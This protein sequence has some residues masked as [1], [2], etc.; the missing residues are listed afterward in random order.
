MSG[1]YYNVIKKGSV[2]KI[3]ERDTDQR[4]GEPCSDDPA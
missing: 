1:C 4:C 2:F 3:I